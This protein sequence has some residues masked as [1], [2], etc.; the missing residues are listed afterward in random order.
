M[1]QRLGY[2]GSGWGGKREEGEEDTYPGNYK[3]KKGNGGTWVAQLVKRLTSAQV[4]ISRF[5]GS[6]P[7]LGSVLT[8][9]E[10]GACFRFCVSLSLYPS[11]AHTVCVCV[12]VSLSLS[13]INI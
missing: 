3:K 8:A 11:P 13:K 4:T 9:P 2:V 12:C 5:M 10:P 7:V 1:R 6:R